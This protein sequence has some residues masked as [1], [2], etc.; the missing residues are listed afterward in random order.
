ML[1]SYLRT[2]Q[3]DEL[4]IAIVPIL[5]GAGERLFDHLDGAPDGYE[6][7]EHVSTAAVTHVRFAK[8]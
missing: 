5:L 8:V 3:L 1:Q 4:H 2:R 6:C 7:V